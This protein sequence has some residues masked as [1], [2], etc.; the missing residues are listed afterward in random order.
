MHIMIY[1]FLVFL[2]VA[3]CHYIYDNVFLPLYR[4]KLTYEMFA[5]RD[6]LRYLAFTKREDLDMEVVFL[7]QSIIN[8]IISHSEILDLRLLKNTGEMVINNP[9]LLKLIEHN[10]ALVEECNS[11]ELLDIHKKKNAIIKEFLIFNTLGMIVDLIPTAL[12][13]LAF[14]SVKYLYKKIIDWFGVFSYVP[15]N[16]STIRCNQI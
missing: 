1:L 13:I 16:H 4:T 14:S 8:N 5:L 6:E 12:C 3:I 10:K 2:L 15:K 9:E 11:K 7:L